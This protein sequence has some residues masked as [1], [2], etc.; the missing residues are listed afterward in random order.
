MKQLTGSFL[1]LYLL[2][3]SVTQTYAAAVDKKITTVPFGDKIDGRIF[4]YNRTA[5][6]IATAGLIKEGGIEL[7]VTEGFRTVIDLRTPPEGTAV[8]QAAMEIAGIEYMNIPIGKEAPSTEDVGRFASIVDDEGRGPLL[9]HCVSANRVGTLWA[10]YR[11]STGVLLQTAL[12]EGRT[13]GMKPT[14]ESNVVEYAAT[15][16]PD[17]SQ[18]QT[19]T[20]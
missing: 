19:T 9:V 8:E 10:M 11:V 14:R 13:V 7:L 4:N 15:I 2:V 3:A 20:D 5:P 12:E 16:L 17:S 6:D 1:L 18:Q